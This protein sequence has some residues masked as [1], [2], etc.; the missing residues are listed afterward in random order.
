MADRPRAADDFATIRARMEQLRHEKEA[1]QAGSS[2]AP[3]SKKRD[4]INLATGAITTIIS[5]I[6]EYPTRPAWGILVKA[7]QGTDAGMGQK[8]L[9]PL[10]P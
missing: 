3:D 8:N 7:T 1:A 4:Y 6:Q 2:E 5:R 9:Y 10:S